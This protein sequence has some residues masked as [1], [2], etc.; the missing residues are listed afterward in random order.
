MNESVK[1]I[2]FLV[3]D[4]D[5]ENAL[6]GMLVRPKSLGIRSLEYSIFV[7][8]RRDPGCRT[9]CVR[10]LRPFAR[11][12]RYAVVLFDY[13]GSGKE[14]HS[15]EALQAEL[16][17]DLAR[18]GWEDRARIIIIQPELEAW[19]WSDS[20]QVDSILGWKD[21][22]TNLRVWLRENGLLEQNAVK[23][24]DP[25]K[26]ML[27]TLREIRKP[28]SSSLFRQIAEQVSLNRCQDAAFIRLRETLRA[29][30]SVG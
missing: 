11:Q 9:E 22:P 1:D 24:Q 16:E 14:K 7:H 19:V 21:S 10:F 2:V 5:M 23:P 13:Q 17:A 25:K 26:A 29:W 18:N 20:P 15:L 8:P 12:F 4:K 6:N 28:L 30:F 3:A 27:Q